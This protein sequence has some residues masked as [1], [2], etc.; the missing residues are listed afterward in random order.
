MDLHNWMDLHNRAF[1]A[2]IATID[3]ESV[4]SD[5][6]KPKLRISNKNEGQGLVYHRAYTYLP[7]KPSIDIYPSY[8]PALP[9]AIF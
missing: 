2:A 3:R 1:T 8:L 4:K 6:K 5:K 9:P 7:K